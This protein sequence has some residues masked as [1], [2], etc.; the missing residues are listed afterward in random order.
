VGGHSFGQNIEIPCALYSNPS[1]FDS[2]HPLLIMRSRDLVPKFQ[3]LLCDQFPDEN[4]AIFLQR[5]TQMWELHKRKSGLSCSR[6][7]DCEQFWGMGFHRGNV[8]GD[9][10]LVASK[11]RQPSTQAAPEP[12]VPRKR[13]RTDS[14]PG[15]NVT[16]PVSSLP[17]P[18]TADAGTRDAASVN[19]RK[20]GNLK[21]HFT[22]PESFPL[23]F[24]ADIPFGFYSTT[25]R[26][27]SSTVCTITSIDPSGACKKEN[28]HIPKGT[29][30]KHCPLQ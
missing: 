1:P 2:L 30:G 24:D 26:T 23:A 22:Q 4:A 21:P 19:S 11:K 20:R 3:Q 27:T 28:A 8:L 25:E 17:N 13:S 7:C 10:P 14:K 29:R 15:H 6:D 5:I 12:R 16:Q 9:L 18:N